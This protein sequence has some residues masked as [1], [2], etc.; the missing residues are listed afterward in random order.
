MFKQI[1]TKEKAKYMVDILHQLL[2][3]LSV[4]FMLIAYSQWDTNFLIFSWVSAILFNQ[5]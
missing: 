2:L 3:L 4:V 5:E 1:M